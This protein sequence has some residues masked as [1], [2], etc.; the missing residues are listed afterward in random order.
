M[1]VGVT[2]A[3]TGAIVQTS[4]SSFTAL[5]PSAVTVNTNDIHVTV[6]LSQLPSTGASPSQ[7][8][9]ISS[10]PPRRR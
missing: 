5:D 4:G 10:R 6:P 9:V 7:Y 2:Q 3:G 1:I 8:R